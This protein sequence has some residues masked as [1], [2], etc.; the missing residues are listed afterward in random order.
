[1]LAASSGELVACLVR[2]PTEV[3]KTRAQT[4]AYGLKGSSLEAAKMVWRTEGARGFG[5]GFGMTVAREVSLTFTA[6]KKRTAMKKAKR[7]EMRSRRR[8]N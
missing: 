8:A 6:R 2:V 7:R 1:M 4:S 5:R 3:I